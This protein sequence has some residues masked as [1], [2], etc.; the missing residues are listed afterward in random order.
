MPVPLLALL[1]IAGGVTM[2]ASAGWDLYQRHLYMEENSRFWSDYEKQ[3]GFSPRYERRVGAYNDYIGAVLGASS[4]AVYASSL[5]ATN[6]YGGRGYRSDRN[7][8]PGY[9]YR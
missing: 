6:I 5:L 3:T 9:M 1:G 2:G 7:Y 8:D 4:R